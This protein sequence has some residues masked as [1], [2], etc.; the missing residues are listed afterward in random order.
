MTYKKSITKKY[1]GHLLVII[2]VSN[3]LVFGIHHYITRESMTRQT[4]ETG[5]DLME[6]NLNMIEQYFEDIDNIAASIIYNPEI[7]RFMKSDLDK[8]SQLELLYGVES[9][10]YNS[11]PDLN[12]SFYKENKYT[13]VY[14]IMESNRV[15]QISDYRY[16]K[17]YQE[18]IWTDDVKVLLTN[19]DEEDSGFVHSMIYRIEDI[20]ENETVGYLKIDM[21]LNDLNRRFPHGYSQV[22]GTTITDKNGNIL[23]LD[24]MQVEVPNELYA[25]KEIGTY[26]TDEYIMSY[27][28]SQST[29]WRLCMAM[30]KEEMFR[31]QNDMIRML[32]IVLFIIIVITILASNQL[33]S[34]VTVNFKRLV[35]GMN[36]VK[37]GNLTTHVEADTADEISILIHEFNE[38]VTRVDSLV[39]TV[40]G[41]QILLKE[42]EIKALQQQINPHFMHNIM[43]TIMG[44]ASEG[45][46]EEVIQV[47]ECM[48]DM[49]RYNTRFENITTLREEV[50]QIRNYISILKIRFEDRFEAYYDIDEECM[51]C[52]IVKFTLQPLVENAISHGLAETYKDGMLRIRIKR[53][54]ENISI[55]VYDNG[56]GIEEERL[57]EMRRRLE[58]TAEHP[59]DY[60]DQY[61]NLGVLNVHLRL[62]MYYGEAYSIELFSK[63]GK[64]TCISIK[65]PYLLPEWKEK[66]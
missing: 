30:S 13:N 31:S 54:G 21:D 32:V 47:S 17:W 7:I 6:T 9:L 28:I 62:R 14:S 50:E 11:R 10:Y 33:F 64:G 61:K 48:S 57:A 56:V 18:I 55:L 22:A 39:K 24:R 16:S 23:F 53:E 35:D 52:N 26:E 40:E 60:I 4:M 59:L 65:I 51:E 5:L 8:A 20:Y 58:Q 3:L 42:A 15:T 66:A 25:G 45:M 37:E 38:M 2:I 36:R 49:L 43:E 34:V 12:I 29:G 41:K 46:N 63:T 27:G 1:L 19:S 44:L